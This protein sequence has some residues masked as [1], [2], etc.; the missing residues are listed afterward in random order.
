MSLIPRDVPALEA[1]MGIVKLFGHPI[2]Q[3]LIVFPLGLLATA[4]IF[5]VIHLTLGGPGWANASFYMIGAG[6]AGGLLAAV[7]GLIDFLSIPGRTRAKRIGALHGIG[8]VVVVG[9]YAASFFLR[10]QTPGAPSIGA[11]ALAIAGAS[12]AAL[13]G[14]L[15][16][17]LVNRLGVGVDR[18]ANV[19]APSSLSHRHADEDHRMAAD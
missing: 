2:H 15:G 9:L 17:E 4:T 14:W 1:G 3:M 16:G 10:M 13:T 11:I 7:F 18:G 6:V 5:D 19:N 12:L 8:N